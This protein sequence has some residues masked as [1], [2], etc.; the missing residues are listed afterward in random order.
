M[1]IFMDKKLLSW[2]SNINF[3]R[4]EIKTL[5]VFISS[6]GARET[7]SEKKERLEKRLSECEAEVAAAEAV[8]ALLTQD[9]REVTEL[10]LIEKK[11]CASFL[12]MEKLRMG[13]AAIYRLRNSAVKKLEK[14]SAYF[15]TS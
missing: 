14:V 12:L 10:M 5:K 6:Y 2:F 4:A 13:Q 3:R 9:E 8:L 15:E 1:E 7:C 11:P